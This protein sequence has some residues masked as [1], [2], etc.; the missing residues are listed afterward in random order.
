MNHVGILLLK[1]PQRGE[2]ENNQSVLDQ[3]MEVPE[4][5]TRSIATAAIAALTGAITGDSSDTLIITAYVLSTTYVIYI[6][7]ST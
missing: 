4:P 7:L 5:V 6:L 3:L 1:G 2:Q